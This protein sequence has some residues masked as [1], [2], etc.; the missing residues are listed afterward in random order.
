MGSLA[1][2]QDT[3][4]EYQDRI[5]RDIS[6]TAT[7]ITMADN[8]AGI[9]DNPETI[10]ALQDIAAAAGFFMDNPGLAI[11]DKVELVTPP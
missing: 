3:D 8:V 4:A 9:P 6:R 7:L 2:R 10:A 11:I 5:D 1:I